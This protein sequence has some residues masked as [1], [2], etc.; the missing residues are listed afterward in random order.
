MFLNP[1]LAEL[2]NYRSEAGGPQ[3]D[4]PF[5]P[6][7]VKKSLYQQTMKGQVYVLAVSWFLIKAAQFQRNITFYQD[8]LL[9]GR[10]RDLLVF[11]YFIIAML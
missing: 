5:I 3:F 2:Q 4:S 6:T 8:A 7:R 9:G 1:V 11:V 10:T